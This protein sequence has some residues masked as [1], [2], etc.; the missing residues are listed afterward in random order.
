MSG[1]IVVVG[2][3][4]GIGSGKSTVA[5]LLAAK[6][7]VIV[8]AD[9]IAR[10]VVEPGAPALE[11]I[12]ARF[13]RD[14]LD[15]EGGLDRARLAEIVFQ[16]VD[17][18]KDLEAITH[19]AIQNE[20]ARQTLEGAGRG[21]VIIL[22]IPLLKERREPMA[23]VIVVDTP[24]ESAINRLVNQ[25]NFDPEDARRRIAAQIS[26]EQRRELADVVIDNSGDVAELTAEVERVWSWLQGLQAEAPGIVTPPG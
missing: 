7:A 25:R 23:G 24:E 26:R 12:V 9:L 18:R 14:V 5:T 22:D 1:G 10:Q 4:G 3:T 17:A 21:S 20:M 19:P 2:L 15:A 16:D 11:S 8:D 6:G 13:G